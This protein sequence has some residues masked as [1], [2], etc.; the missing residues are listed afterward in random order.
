M[1]FHAAVYKNTHVLVL[2][3]IPGYTAV[4][5]CMASDWHPQTKILTNRETAYIGLDSSVGRVPVR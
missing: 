4:N 2:L 3:V 5:G 1:H